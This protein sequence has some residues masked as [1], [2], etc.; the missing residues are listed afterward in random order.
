MKKNAAQREY[1]K[2]AGQISQIEKIV[3]HSNI[4][5]L[6]EHESVLRKKILQL[7]EIENQGFKDYEAIYNRYEE[8]LEEVGKRILE[9]YNKKNRTDFEK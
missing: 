4:G 7:K 1:K 9:N 2:L 5:A 6:F 8:L 3:K